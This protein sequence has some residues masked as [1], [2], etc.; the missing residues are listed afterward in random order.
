MRWTWMMGAFG[1]GLFPS[2]LLAGPA[3]RPTSRP[4]AAS[5]PVRVGAVVPRQATSLKVRVVRPAAR[6]VWVKS[7]SK[8]AKVPTSKPTTRRAP[9]V[10]TKPTPRRVEPPSRRVKV[11]VPMRPPERR[12]LV[13]QRPAPRKRW[14]AP[15]R[16]PKLRGP[17]VSGW[18]SFTLSK[19][20]DIWLDGQ[21]LGR[22]VIA[23]L[24]LLPGAHRVKVIHK[25]YG[26]LEIPVQVVANR[27][28]VVMRK[29]RRVGTRRSRWERSNAFVRTY[30]VKGKPQEKVVIP[31]RF[32]I[33]KKVCPVLMPGDE[34]YVQADGRY[35]IVSSKMATRSTQSYR[36]RPGDGFLTL[37]SYPPGALFLNKKLV[38]MAPVAKLPVRPGKYKMRVKNGYL[39]MEWSGWLV[40]KEGKEVRKVVLTTPSHKVGAPGVSANIVVRSKQP[41][42]IFVDGL[43]RGWTPARVLPS[44]P[45]KHVVTLQYPNGTVWTSRFTLW[46]GQLEIVD[47]P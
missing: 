32:C 33:R 15:A 38:A 45:G 46:Q 7:A 12:K 30:D 41:A 40:V 42:R 23:Y 9:V 43:Y 20:D 2:L 35:V 39:N 17:F 10:R 13:V 6:T 1:L 14:V 26:V 18:L 11:V 37:Y 4:A 36:K 5:R 44:T 29:G 34:L 19:K 27:H 16:L 25:T 47:G 31:G 3:S 28:V 21:H 8:P 24:R 22:G